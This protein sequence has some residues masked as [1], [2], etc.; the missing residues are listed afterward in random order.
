MI[1]IVLFIIIY[2]I[3]SWNTSTYED[4]LYGFWVAEDDDFCEEAEIDSMLL[5]IGEAENGVRTVSRTCYIIIMTN[6]SNQGFTL[7][8]VPGWGGPGISKYHIHA[9]PEF[10][11]EDLWG[12]NVTLE[13]NISEGTLKIYSGDT[14]YAKL[15][16]QHDTTNMAR[17]LDGADC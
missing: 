1:V 2:F 8:Y 17:E 3:L 11:D 6:M 7:N 14:V 16:K 15:N 13:I 12:D 10:D 4:Y 9:T 5:F